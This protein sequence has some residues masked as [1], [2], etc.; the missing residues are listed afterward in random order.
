MSPFSHPV[1]YGSGC[2]FCEVWVSL[3]LREWNDRREG[4][5]R[6]VGRFG[7]GSRYR[8]L[9]PQD[10]LEQGDPRVSFGA[11]SLRRRRSS[12]S[13]TRFWVMVAVLAVVLIFMLG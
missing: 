9:E 6:R 4:A 1:T 5:L 3:F 10:A 8:D 13:Q 12:L 2:L 11:R 7:G